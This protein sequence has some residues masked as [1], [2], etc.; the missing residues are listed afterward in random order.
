MAQPKG[1]WTPETP[2]FGPDKEHV[3]DWPRYVCRNPSCKSYGKSHPNCQ[4]GPPSLRS[5]YK[6]LEYADGGYIHCS[7]SRA[8]DESCEHYADGGEIEANHEFAMN[9]MLALDHTIAN[10]GLLH[11]FTKTGRSRSQN[12][13][14]PAEEFLE[15]S[16]RGRKLIEE[17]AKAHFDPKHEDVESDKA[18]ISAL[19][20]H[21]DEIQKNPSQLLDLGG[22]LGLPDHAAALGAKAAQVTNY[23]DGIRPKQAIPGLLDPPMP[24][25]KMADQNYNRQLGI[26]EKPLSIL[27]HI[28]NGTAQPQDIQTINALYPNLSQSL[29]NKTFDALIEAKTN[30]KKIPYKHRMGLSQFFGQP[31]DAS[32]APM[33]IQSIMKANAGAQT[34]SQGQQPAKQEKRGPTAETQKTI[35]R[36]DEL[37][38][39][40]LEKIQTSKS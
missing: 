38:K 16:K 32:L 26:A 30:E 34:Q 3:A 15:S 10:H 12:S 28:R 5:Q 24:V 37:Y 23:F 31:L 33:A 19:R 35:A 9:P 29:R 18:N 40:P 14:R 25:D 4:C 27:G 22:S 20:T 11:A 36:A 2:W 1:K 17:H 13:N 6:Q 21:L 7:G 39:T 8:H